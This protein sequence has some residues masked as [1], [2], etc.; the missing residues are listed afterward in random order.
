MSSL[1]F[2]KDKGALIRRQ[3][4]GTVVPREGIVR[5][6]H[7]VLLK[8]D[9]PHMMMSSVLISLSDDDMMRYNIDDDDEM[10]IIVCLA[11]II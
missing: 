7:E 6:R 2:C 1:A 3:G 11:I 4:V 9:I 10:I 8:V 5:W